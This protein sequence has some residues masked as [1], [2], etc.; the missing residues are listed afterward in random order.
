[1]RQNPRAKAR[2]RIVR[3]FSLLKSPDGRRRRVG[4]AGRS[5]VA[6][7]SLNKAASPPI[8]GPARPAMRAKVHALRFRGERAASIAIWEAIDKT[9]SASRLKHLRKAALWRPAVLDRFPRRCAP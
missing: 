2:G 9:P 8:G 3:S 5:R 6:G 7:R 4:V 1:M